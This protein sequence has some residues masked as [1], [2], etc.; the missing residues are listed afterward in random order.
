MTWRD[1]F[2]SNMV[3]WMKILLPLAA[4]GI[5]STVFML[6]RSVDPSRSIPAAAVDVQKR[7]RDQGATRPT[8]AGVTT[9]GDQ[10]SLSADSARPHPDHKERIIA[11]K[12]RTDVRLTGGTVIEMRAETAEIDQDAL[13]ADLRGDVTFETSA[14]YSLHTEALATS[15]DQLFAESKGAVSGKAPAG[16][17]EAGRMRLTSR[18]GSG[19]AELIFANGVKLVYKPA[20]SGD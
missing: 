1:N 12:V 14:G 2:Y 6:S 3:A 10:V 7:A 13:T 8:F 18:P 19:D 4:L 17:L 15:Y 16:R 20:K 9:G 5:L 11:R